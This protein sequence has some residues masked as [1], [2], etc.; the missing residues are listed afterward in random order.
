M[1]NSAKI[2]QLGAKMLSDADSSDEQDFG[3]FYLSRFLGFQTTY[4]DD[5]CIVSFEAKSPMFNPQGTLHGGVIA[6][7]LDVSMGHLLHHKMGAGATLEMNV[8]YLGSKKISKVAIPQSS[9]FV[10]IGCRLSSFR[11][12]L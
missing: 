11:F 9:W 10:L 1:D 2:K 7:A 4:K 8:K 3:S 6:T 12:V 5:L